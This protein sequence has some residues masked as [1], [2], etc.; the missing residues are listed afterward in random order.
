[1]L[2]R[3]LL[4]QAALRRTACGTASNDHPN[5]SNVQRHRLPNG[6]CIAL[7]VTASMLGLAITRDGA[8]AGAFTS[9]G[10]E[11]WPG[12]TWDELGIVHRDL[13]SWPS[14]HIKRSGYRY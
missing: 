11:C 6:L 5:T 1:M 4:K 14:R 10:V 13:T 3:H 8:R 7:L 2:S 9:D 12:I